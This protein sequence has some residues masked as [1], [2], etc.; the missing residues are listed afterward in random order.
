[1]IHA[2]PDGPRRRYP[3]RTLDGLAH[4]CP[5]LFSGGH[6]CN[7]YC[8]ATVHASL[9]YTTARG[10]RRVCDLWNGM[11]DL[12]HDDALALQAEPVDLP[13]VAGAAA[14]LV[15]WTRIDELRQEAYWA[16]IGASDE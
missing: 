16:E 14:W 8:V 10:R 15:Y 2:Q 13:P 4:V 7:D 12:L 9:T 6:V 3:A 1:M 5:V 11:A